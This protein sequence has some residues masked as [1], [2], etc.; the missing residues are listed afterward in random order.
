MFRAAGAVVGLLKSAELT[1]VSVQPAVR[2]IER[3]FELVLETLG[4]PEPS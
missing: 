3:A 4:G 2:T 1:L